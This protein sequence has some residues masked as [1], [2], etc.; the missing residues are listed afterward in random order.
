M[1]ADFDRGTLKRIFGD[2]VHL[3]RRRRALRVGA[4]SVIGVIVVAA[5]GAAGG[6]WGLAFG[7][8]LLMGGLWW[9]TRTIHREGGLTDRE[10]RAF[11]EIAAGFGRDGRGPAGA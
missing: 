10:R 1:V 6:I 9:A 3:D 2:S 5:G 7:T 4:V 11:E 8:V